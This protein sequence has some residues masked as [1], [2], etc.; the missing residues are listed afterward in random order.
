M[1]GH[2]RAI[3]LTTSTA[4]PATSYPKCMHIPVYIPSPAQLFSTRSADERAKTPT[5]QSYPKPQAQRRSADE[6][7]TTP[8]PQSY[9]KPQAQRRADE[10][11]TTPTPQSHPKPRKDP[12]LPPPLYSAEAPFRVCA[13]ALSRN[14]LMSYAK[15]HN[16]AVGTHDLNRRHF[17]WVEITER[18]RPY[19]H[20]I[21][22][23]KV[24]GMVYTSIVVGTNET[25]EDM[26]KAADEGVIKNIQRIVGLTKPPIWTRPQRA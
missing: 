9:P 4:P 11:A 1:K 24:V 22:V 2:R 26:A 12:R 7:A 15:R 14:T 10:R 16:I 21:A 8:A 25:P 13:F 3:D 23:I 5:P 20:R 19:A 17:A 6:R 18:V